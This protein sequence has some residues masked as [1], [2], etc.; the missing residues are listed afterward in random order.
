MAQSTTKTRPQQN[1]EIKVNCSTCSGWHAGPSDSKLPGWQFEV[2]D[3][4]PGK[5]TLVIF[6]H[7]IFVCRLGRVRTPAKWVVSWRLGRPWP[8]CWESRMTRTSLTWWWAGLALSPFLLWSFLLAAHLTHSHPLVSC[9]SNSK[10][11]PFFLITL[12][13]LILLLLVHLTHSPP[14]S[15]CPPDSLSPLFFLPTLLILTLLLH[16]GFP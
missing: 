1:L 15:S 10:S 3:A 16:N 2:L 14:P 6:L 4:N 9:S 13:I 7:V 8:W 11:S 12:I 5:T